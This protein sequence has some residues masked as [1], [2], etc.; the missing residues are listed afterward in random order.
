MS[1]STDHTTAPATE[2]TDPSPT[3]TPEPAP[4]APT[5]TPAPAEPAAALLPGDP[6]YGVDVA[7][8]ED[9]EPLPLPTAEEMAEAIDA[10]HDEQPSPLAAACA[11]GTVRLFRLRGTGTTRRL[12]W[13]TGEALEAAEWYRLRCDQGATVRQVAEQCETSKATV[14]RAL[15]TLALMDEITD[16]LHDDLYAEDVTEI[17]FG[18]GDGDDA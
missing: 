16:G 15:A 4:A 12:P 14:R 11:A 1:T 17:V 5:A 3:Q 7:V 6:T 8:P 2:A 13:L 9:T 10:W 18:A